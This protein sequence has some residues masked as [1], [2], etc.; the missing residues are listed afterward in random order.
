MTMPLVSIIVPTYNRA[1]LLRETLDSVAVQTHSHWECVIVDDRSTDG[2]ATLVE[3]YCRRDRRFRYVVKSAE[4]RRGAS[5]SRNLGLDVTSGDL[6]QFLDSDDL[7]APN[8]LEAQ[9]AA[10]ARAGRDALVSCRWELFRTS[11]D[12]VTLSTVRQDYRDFSSAADYFDLIGRHGGFFPP[13]CFLVSRRVIHRAGGWNESLS[14]NDDG[15][16][17][18]RVICAADGIV[19][20]ADTHA[21]Y[22]QSASETL[23]TLDSEDKARSLVASWRIIE[24]IYAARFGDG[25]S[26][27]LTRKKDGIYRT[28]KREYPQLV[29]AY[30]GF[31]ADQIARDSVA[32][33][34]RQLTRRISR[35]FA[36]V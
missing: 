1:A 28:L 6:V 24:A 32:L 10:L 9:C 35:R 25:P 13:I 34:V 15:E 17:F 12:G 3:E 18:F 30:A 29:R 11:A 20:A 5:S 33:R 26:P 36:G 21:R 16:F 31:F 22:R 2:T 19:F 8:K 27:Y 4:A 14:M 7:I 23:S